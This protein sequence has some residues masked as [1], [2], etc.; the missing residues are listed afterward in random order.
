MP[1]AHVV[2]AN[3][4]VTEKG[5]CWVWSAI[6]VAIAEDRDKDANLFIEDVGKFEDFY[7]E[8]RVKEKLEERDKDIVHSIA[9]CAEDPSVRF[10]EIY[11]GHKYQYVEEN[12]VG[13]ALACA[14]YVLLARYAIPPKGMASDILDMT[15]DEWEK[16]L[17]LPPLN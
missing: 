2:C 7:D 9:L 5:P 17:N 6:A 12:N 14:P 10:K 15:I 3:K 13:C 16:A 11:V 4:S 8:D 1:G